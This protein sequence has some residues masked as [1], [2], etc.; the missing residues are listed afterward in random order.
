[1]F[2]RSI[3]CWIGLTVAAVLS[4]CS[5]PSP[6]PSDGAPRS[7]DG[8]NP[9]VC[10]GRCFY[11]PINEDFGCPA[12]LV[13][14][15]VPPGGSSC[16]G[17][18]HAGNCCLMD[19]APTAPLCAGMCVTSPWGDT[20]SFPGTRPVLNCPAGSVPDH[21]SDARCTTVDDDGVCCVPQPDGGPSADGGGDAAADAG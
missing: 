5:T 6:G 17:D 7:N 10:A 11:T 16:T 15:G 8:A 18:S 2:A 21:A 3:S 12:G 13:S 19:P 4:G 20:S 9:G 14:D 1:M